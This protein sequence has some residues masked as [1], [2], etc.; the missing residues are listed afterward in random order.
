VDELT[1]VR[2]NRRERF[3]TTR[4]VGPKG[5]G[6]DGHGNPTLSAKITGFSVKAPSFVGSDLQLQVA[7]ESLQKDELIGR[8][9]IQNRQIDFNDAPRHVAFSC[10]C[11]RDT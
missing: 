11:P 6:Q 1:G 10:V 3:W 2:Q 8:F 5:Y 4:S 7:L 9:D